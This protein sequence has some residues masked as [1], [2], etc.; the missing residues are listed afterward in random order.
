M[1]AKSGGGHAS[2]ADFMN[3]NVT[4]WNDMTRKMVRGNPSELP[5]LDLQNTPRMTEHLSLTRD[6][7]HFKTARGRRWINDVS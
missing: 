3:G 4:R 2:G 5:L 1:P 7:I 6:G